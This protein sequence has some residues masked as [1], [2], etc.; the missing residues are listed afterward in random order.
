M[1][2]KVVK[3]KA[4]RVPTEHLSHRTE[5]WAPEN[6]KSVTSRSVTRRCL[7]RWQHLTTS[8]SENIAEFRK[9]PPGLIQHVLTVLVFVGGGKRG[10]YERGLFT[11]GISR[12]SKS[13]DSLESLENGRILIYPPQSGGSLES[14]ESH[15]SLESL[16]N[17]LFW[18]DPFSKRPLFQNPILGSW[19]LLL[20]RLPPSSRS[21][22]C[23]MGAWTFAWIC[24][25]Q[26]TYH[27]CKNG[28]HSTCLYSTGG[29]T[30][31][32]YLCQIGRFP[33]EPFLVTLQGPLVPIGRYWCPPWP[34]L[35]SATPRYSLLLSAISCY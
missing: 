8:R 31:M 24:C 14:L 1:L 16:E 18:K 7:T 10:H 12:I 19:V 33:M 29:H 6:P 34:S 21:L 28:T 4:R 15:N 22:F 27:P 20:P 11:G 3:K 5:S 32:N 13:L 9:R 2:R 23:F 30:P 35:F 26:L 25:P 17:G